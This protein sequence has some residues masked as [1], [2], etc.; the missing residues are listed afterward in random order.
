[1]MGREC[2]VAA[3]HYLAA[4]AGFE[5]LKAGGNAVDAGVA[6]GLAT[7]VLQSD[8]VNVAGVAPT[9]IW[10]A[11]RGEIVSIDGLG[12]WPRS[13][14]P[15]LFEREHQ[16]VIPEG[17]LRTLVPAAPAAWLT[18]LERYGTMRSEEHTSELQSLMRISYAVFCLKKKNTTPNMIDSNNE[19]TT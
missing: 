3:G 16:G 1:M 5:I 4:E 8:I 12:T 7:G 10:L 9:L 14:L 6:M 11:D 19:Y 2:A 17:L 18:A 13:M 15:D